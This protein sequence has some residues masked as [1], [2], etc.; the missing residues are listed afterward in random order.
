M[1]TRRRKLVAV[2][3]GIVMIYAL[4]PFIAGLLKTHDRRGPKI[5]FQGHHE[6]FYT[7]GYYMAGHHK[8]DGK[9]RVPMQ[10]QS[11]FYGVDG[12][13]RPANESTTSR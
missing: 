11:W 9:P 1:I 6:L 13:Q 12:T 7:F 8:Y 5:F 2:A 4:T 3:L 10:E